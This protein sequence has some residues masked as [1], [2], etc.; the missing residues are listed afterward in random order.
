MKSNLFNDDFQDLLQAFN[1][2]N[3]EY[4]LVGGYA[5]II[6]GY[7]RTTGDLD[8][9]VNQTSENYFKLEKAF[10]IF[11]MP[12]FDMTLERFLDKT[13]LDVFEFGRP[14]IAIDILTQ[15]KGANFKDIF[16]NSIKYEVEEDFIVNVIHYD[17]LLEVKLAANRAKDINDIEM[18]GKKNKDN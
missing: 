12:L 7:S 3:V 11:G 18:L 17:N 6:H 4:V 14:P 10:K 1:K 15:I 2:V 5:V 13:N 8:L 9:L 16:D